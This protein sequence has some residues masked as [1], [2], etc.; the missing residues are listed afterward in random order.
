MKS[1]DKRVQRTRRALLDAFFHLVLTR[2][3]EEITV[4]LIAA[5]AGVGRSSFYEHFRGKG[6]LLGASLA[7]PFG[8][9]ADAAGAADNTRALTALLEHFWA[10]RARARGIFTGPMRVHAVA[11]L[12]RLIQER[13]R[14]SPGQ[15]AA[16]L[17]LP[18]RLAALQ[19][20]EALFAP[21]SA[22]LT[23]E[24]DC[25]APRLARALRRSALALNA[26]LRGPWSAPQ[27]AGFAPTL[28]RRKS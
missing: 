1:A 18:P 17:L 9:L 13:W 4:Q 20:A 22:W 16:A 7:A 28:A 14:A 19:L 5:R 26:A 10:N 24:T 25:S 2:P 27:E 8:V 21:L 6:A 15:R 12:A 11:V 3:Y 23:S